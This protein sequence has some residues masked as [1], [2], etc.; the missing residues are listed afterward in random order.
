MV[1]ALMRRDFESAASVNV[2]TPPL[3]M[4]ITGI[5][6]IIFGGIIDEVEASL[7]PQLIF[8]SL[9]V[10]P[11]FLIAR[12]YSVKAGLIAAIIYALD[13]YLIQYSLTYLDALATFFT[14]MSLL[15]ILDKP[16]NYCLLFSG[17]LLG[18]ASLTKLTFL[19]YA[20]IFTLMLA[21]YRYGKKSLIILGTSLPMLL[22]IPWLWFSY[23][24]T[25]AVE[26]HL[27]FNSYLPVVFVGPEIIGVPQAHA[28]Y[29]LSY[30]GL[31]QVFWNT[32]PFITPLILLFIIVYRFLKRELYLPLMPSIA[33]SA[34]ILT[35]FL[36][37]RNYWTYSWAGGALQGILSRQFYPY[38]FYPT[39]PF[40]AVLA[41][42]LLAGGQGD[43]VKS[44]LLSYPIFMAALV[45][46]IAV[47][48]NLGLPY[49]DFIFTLIYNYSMGYWIYEG[50]LAIIITG[51][52]LGFFLICAELFHK[53]QRMYA[54]S[55]A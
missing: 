41:G 20:V 35:I 29:V 42:I 1:E 53:R 10:F 46:P 36:L 55:L 9:T 43:N 50:L 47:V 44:R 31:G 40:I 17:I 12:R 38:Y 48:M 18:L 21:Y 15:I 14:L 6:I 52:L 11:V 51:V 13:P 8:S 24:R 7:I 22:L 4:L 54:G 28:W 39:G 30:I 32:L 2:G 49:W 45:S 19:L 26:H 34:M 5:F 3:G 27:S 25:K 16:N 23:A 33:A 37:P